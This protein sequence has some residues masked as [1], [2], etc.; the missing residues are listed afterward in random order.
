MAESISAI[1]TN[2][3]SYTIAH[4]CCERLTNLL[5]DRQSDAILFYYRRITGIGVCINQLARII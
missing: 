5:I 2:T 1:I 3:T 4:Y